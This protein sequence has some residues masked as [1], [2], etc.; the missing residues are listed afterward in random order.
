MKP[1]VTEAIESVLAQTRQDF[2]VV[3][4]DSGQWVGRGDEEMR[5]AHLRHYAHPK[6]RW[7]FTN[8]PADL[9]ASRCP[10]SWA[11]N[12]TIRKGGLGDY[13]CT[14]YDDDL[15]YPAFFERM[16]GYLDEHP[17]ALAV[18]CSQDRIALDRNG[19]TR[20]TGHIP[21]TG[22]KHP[23][24]MDCRV[25][26]A[27]V[28]FRRE[29]LDLIGD[30]WM[31]E[32]PG[33]CGHSDGLFLERLAQVCGEIPAIPDTLLAHRATPISTYSPT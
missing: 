8:E 1:Y 22:P 4:V 32:N 26:G 28:M 14:F 16:A 7:T 17:D 27:Q 20:T 12:L 10:V 24:E 30:P 33:T 25:D 6:V 11:T 3:V 19:Q 2:E 18:W 9:R 15:Y 13:I 23:G 29:A 31:D 5:R 21:A